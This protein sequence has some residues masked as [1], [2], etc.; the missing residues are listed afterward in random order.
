MI[1]YLRHGKVS[2]NQ[3]RR[4]RI[5]TSSCLHITKHIMEFGGEKITFYASR[6]DSQCSGHQSTFGFIG[7]IS[8]NNVSSRSKQ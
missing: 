1:P 8:Q 5:C 6:N 4:L 2:Q 3:R 7:N